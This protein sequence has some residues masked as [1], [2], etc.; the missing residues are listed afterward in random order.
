MPKVNAT[1]ATAIA[2]ALAAPVAVPVVNAQQA[3]ASSAG[4]LEEIVVTARKREESLQDVASSVSAISPEELARRPDVDLSSFA[5]ASPNVIIDDMQEGP[6]SA[7]AMTIRGIGTNDHERSIDPTIG[8]VVDGVF[9]GSVGGAMVKALDLQSVEILRGPQGTLFGR[10]SIGGAVNIVRRRPDSELGGEVRGSYGNYGDWQVDGYLSVPVGETF[11]FKLAGAWNERDGYAYNRTLGKDQ[12]ELK[13]QMISPSFVWRPMD[14]LEVYY[15]YDKTW[16]DQDASVLLNVAQPDQAWCFF[17]N[18]CAPSVHTPQGGDRYV[19]LQNTP[20]PNAQFDTQ[21]HTVNVRY[22]ISDD[23]RI[24]YIFGRFSTDEDAYWDYDGTPLTLYDTLRDQWYNQTSHELRLTYSGDSAFTY[25]VGLYAWDSAYQNDMLS[26]IGFG[27]LLFGLPSGTVLTVPQK[28]RQDTESYA[29]FFEGDLKFGEAWTLTLGGRYTRDEKESRVEDPLFQAQLDQYG[30]YDNPANESWSE[31]TPKLG[32]KYRFNDDLMVYGLYSRGFRAGGFSGRPGTYDAATLPYDPETVDNYELGMKSEWMESRLRFN[33][34]LY[35]MKYNDKQEELSV[36]VNISGGT[37]QQTLF[38]NASQAEIK[39]VEL[40]LTAVPFEGFMVSG[41]LG[42]LDAEYTDFDDPVTGSSL[43]YLELRRAPDITATV[44][45]SYEWSALNGQ[46]SAQMDWH[47]VSDYDNTFWNTPAA[48]NDAQNI[49]DATLNYQINNTQI[50]IFG[51]NLLG[52]DGYTIGLDV[53]RS[54]DF[55]GLWTFTGVRP[56]RT[57][58]IRI[59][60][61]F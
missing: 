34:S 5:N 37:G 25:T 44:S 15:R 55:A 39:G 58:G 50:G 57:Y 20:D 61:K 51:R 31:F 53:G 2:L 7:A 40:E 43:T 49:V 11:A 9:I 45:P 23:Y 54:L 42:F 24:D 33:A 60:Q 52:E 29:A 17:Y 8:V 38:I 30:G 35:Y 41:S 18:Q 1:L 4:G 26:Y 56:P 16:T 10:N 13:Y 47:Y 59:S 12:G 6:G 19:S 46:M 21:T 3:T 14:S 36:P 48:A 27:D 22:D 28:V 32:L